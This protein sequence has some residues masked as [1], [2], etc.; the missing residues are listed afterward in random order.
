MRT[1][2]TIDLLIRHA[3]PTTPQEERTLREFSTH[4]HDN[5]E[6]AP[7]LLR[8]ARKQI[9]KFGWV[10]FDAAWAAALM[11]L[12]VRS[13]SEFKLC[14][15]LKAWY[16]RGLIC[17]NPTRLNGCLEVR[18]AAPDSVFGIAVASVKLP[19]DY[20]RRLQWADGSPLSEP[21]PALG[22][23]RKPVQSVRPAPAQSELFSEEAA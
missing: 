9:R 10:C 3:K 8:H 19:D 14:A 17:C 20:A 4:H 7:F 12:P 23:A 18:S 2:T 13:G 22:C 5:P 21:H 16:V 6:L 1:T 15:R 11:E